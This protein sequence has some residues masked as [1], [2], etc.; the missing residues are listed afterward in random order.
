MDRRWGGITRKGPGVKIERVCEELGATGALGAGFAMLLEGGDVVTLAGDLGAGKTTFVRGVAAGLGVDERAVSSPTFVIVNRY[1]ARGGRVEAVTH[2]DAYR[3]HGED[4]LD[5]VGWDVV[6]REGGAAPGTVMFVE[7]AER[8]AGAMPAECAAVTIES[9]GATAR[10]FVFELPE[11]WRSR[12]A[13]ER[14]ELEPPR[15]CPRT[16]A[17]VAPGSATYPFVDE[18]ARGSD[19]FGW[20]TERY[21]VERPLDETDEPG[22]G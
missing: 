20:M 3:L 9:V 21:R 17:W 15:R 5:N 2:V 10:R 14:F 19:L 22:A 1:A 12:S 8:I 13:F 18:R 4:E 11:R 7:W 16:G 6:M